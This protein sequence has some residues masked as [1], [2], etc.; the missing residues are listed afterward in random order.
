MPLPGLRDDVL[1]DPFD[2][3]RVSGTIAM[4]EP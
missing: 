3:G 2:G 1:V 4:T